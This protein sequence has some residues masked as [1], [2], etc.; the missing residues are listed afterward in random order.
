MLHSFSMVIFSLTI[1]FNPLSSLFTLPPSP[2]L[3]FLAYPEGG[4]LSRGLEKREAKW[5]FLQGIEEIWHQVKDVAKGIFFPETTHIC[6]FILH[7]ALVEPFEGCR[8]DSTSITN[9]KIWDT[10]TTYLFKLTEQGSIR[11]KIWK[12]SWQQ[13]HSWGIQQHLMQFNC[14]FWGFFSPKL[15]SLIHGNHDLVRLPAF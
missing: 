10:K 15:S 7:I 5:K 4:Q 11:M 13:T 14:G 1:T 3:M 9:G 6:H 8:I 12:V 2:L